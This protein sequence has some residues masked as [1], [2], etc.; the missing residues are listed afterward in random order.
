MSDDADLFIGQS[1]VAPQPRWKGV[2]AVHHATSFPPGNDDCE[3]NFSKAK[4]RAKLAHGC[5]QALAGVLIV[6]DQSRSEF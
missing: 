6:H 2:E 5:R 1:E 3:E 4:S